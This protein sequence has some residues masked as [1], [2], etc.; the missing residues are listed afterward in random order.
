MEFNNCLDKQEEIKKCFLSLKSQEKRYLKIIELGQNAPKMAIEDQVEE[1]IVA[2]C[3]SLLY[4]KLKCREG[5]LSLQTS[6]NALISA[7]LAQLL[8]QTYDG[9]PP[10][11]VF[12]CPPHFLKEVGLL[13]S[14]SPSR[15]NGLKSL[16]QKLRKES[17]KFLVSK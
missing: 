12:Q 14:L 8:V 1:N 10:E 13:E 15:A 2:G 3:Q 17:L 16:Y 4:L 7:G 11:V 6:S 9:E 5:K